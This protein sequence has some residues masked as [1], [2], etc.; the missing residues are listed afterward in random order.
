MG[1]TA[2]A[3]LVALAPARGADP[4]VTGKAPQLDGLDDFVTSTMDE[5]KVP[6]LALAVVKDDQVVHL[7]GYGLRDREQQLPVTPGTLFPIASISKSFTATGLGML[8]DAKKLDWDQP[9]REIVPE[10]LLKDPVAS[11]HATTRD[12]LTHR[13]GLPRHDRVWYRAGGSRL[14]AI[15]ALRH[16]EPSREFRA[17]WQYNN[18]MFLAA[19]VVAERVSGRSWEEFTRERIFGPLGMT[20][21]RFMADHPQGASDFAHPYAKLG[22]AVRRIPFY[23]DGPLGPAGGVVSNASELAR[24]LRF[25]M[26]KGRWD[27]HVLLSE[28]AAEQMQTPQGVIPES[29]V[30]PFYAT[31]FPELGHSTYGLG[32]FIT[33]YRGHKLVWHSGSLDGYSLL[34]SFLPREKLG[35]LVLTNLSG[36]RPVP[37]CVTRNI[38]DRLLGAEPIDWVGRC[39]ALD[40]KAESESAAARRKTE[41]ARKTGT[42]PSHVLPEY[43]GIYAHPAYGSVTI[44]A[45]G[46]ALRLT[47]RGGSARLVHRHYDVF[48]T[49]VDEDASDD[50]PVP[51]IRVSFRSERGSRRGPADDAAGAQGRRD[52]L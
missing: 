42:H 43:S 4:G 44:G 47:W 35:V 16:L 1:A 24:Y 46:D 22:G 28:Q 5:W 10:F 48:D 40:R 27:G 34:F 18:L 6:G 19:G 51:R 15:K 37:I 38:F 20:A 31:E 45:A 50:N 36:N 41:A 11:D 33:T 17:S 7:K 2:L 49:D 25:H 52:R 26:N 3:A 12:L 14:E 13:T 23:E 39:K 32:F 8:A 29:E 30:S 9:V 21:S